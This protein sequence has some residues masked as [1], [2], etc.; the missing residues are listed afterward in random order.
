MTSE[1]IDAQAALA[2]VE[3]LHATSEPHLDYGKPYCRGCQNLWPCATIRAIEN[4][5]ETP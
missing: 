1:Q 2:R 4:T 5:K 3:A